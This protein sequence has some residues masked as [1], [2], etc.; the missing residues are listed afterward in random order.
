EL[1]HLADVDAVAEQ[2][3]AL[4]AGGGNADQLAPVVDDGPATV[5]G[6]DRRLRLE[7]AGLEL[8]IAVA[9]ARAVDLAD[10]AGGVDPQGGAGPWVADGMDAVA[11]AGAVGGQLE[12][13]GVVRQRVHLDQGEVAAGLPADDPAAVA[14]AALA[15]IAALGDEP[16]IFVLR[17]E[18]D[19]AV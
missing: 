2:R 18:D 16:A 11:G 12:R 14:P 9:D 19:D 7:D 4:P 10:A 17:E 6:V 13:L 3:G 1:A 8:E 5:A 15:V